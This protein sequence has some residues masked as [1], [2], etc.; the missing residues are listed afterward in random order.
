MPTTRY[1]TR[2]LV[3]A[4]LEKVRE[5]L[6]EAIGRLRDDFL[7]W[8]PT[9]GM[10]TV[11][12][13]LLEIAGTEIQLLAK[14]RGEP[15][16]SWEETDARTDA[17]SLA[18]LKKGLETAR[19]DTLSFI[20]SASDEQLESPAGIPAGWHESLGLT[21]APVGEVLRGLAQHEAY[22]T[23]QLVSYLWARGDN[24]YKW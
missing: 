9:E 12:D 6:D 8:A 24:P 15:D 14:L 22:H 17:S 1:S 16:I 11:R 3:L 5:G 18:G 13:Q 4:R 7:D 20:D 2:E 19:N 21:D 10:R 23:G